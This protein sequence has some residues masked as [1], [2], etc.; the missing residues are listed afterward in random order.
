MLPEV[1]FGGQPTALSGSPNGVAGARVPYATG[2]GEV[3]WTGHFGQYYNLGLT[4]F[5]N[6]N[7]FNEPPFAVLSANVRYKLNDRGTRVQLSADNLT[8]A[9]STPYAGFFNGIPL[10]LVRG[11][12]QT[13]LVTG[14]PVPVSL[15]ATAAGNYGPMS[16]RFIVTQDL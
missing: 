8:G 12:T 4:Y 1:N 14:A 7:S 15:A 6:N 13:S 5:G 16:F 10:P 11:A 2:Y 3:S 9:Y